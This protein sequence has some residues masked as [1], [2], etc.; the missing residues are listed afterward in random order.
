MN[1]LNKS[2]ITTYGATKELK[3]TNLNDKPK[4]PISRINVKQPVVDI[5]DYC[6]YFKK[7]RADYARSAVKTETLNP[8]N[9][10]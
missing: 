6:D 3:K 5:H 4:T 1:I 7:R 9:E 2:S 10:N 8:K